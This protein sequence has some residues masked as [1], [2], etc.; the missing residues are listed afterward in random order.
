MTYPN[1]GP[2][3]CWRSCQAIMAR[4]PQQVGVIQLVEISGGNTVVVSP[5]ACLP[6]HSVILGRGLNSVAWDPV[7]L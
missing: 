7:Y 6:G 3:Y 4:S 5:R 1:L 2:D